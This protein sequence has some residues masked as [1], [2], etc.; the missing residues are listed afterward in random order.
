M[1]RSGGNIDNIIAIRQKLHTHP[2]GGFN[3]F[4]TQQAIIDALKSFGVKDDAITKCAK[5]GL[6]VDLVGTGPKS[7]QIEGVNVVALRADMDGLP[8]PE[9]AKDLPY[10]T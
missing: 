3:E 5:T 1:N 4:K 2:E 7:S 8:I 6:V 10:R 9:N